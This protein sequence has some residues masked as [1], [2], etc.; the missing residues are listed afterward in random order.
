MFY[1]AYKSPNKNAYNIRMLRAFFTTETYTEKDTSEL[2]IQYVD[3]L[4]QQR[5]ISSR[6]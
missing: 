3:Q 5:F 4:F 6:L 2:S 1:F